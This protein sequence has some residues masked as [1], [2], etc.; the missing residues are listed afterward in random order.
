MKNSLLKFTLAASLILNLTVFA[1][2]GY[3]YYHQSRSWVSPFGK[4]MEKDKFLFEELSLKPEQLSAMKNKAM[5]F[6]AEIDRRRMAIDVRKKELVTLMRDQTP[7]KKAIDTIIKE[8]SGKQ[9]EMQRMI[10]GHMLEIKSSLDEGQQ[11]KFF[12]LIERNMAG[13]GQMSCPP[14][15]GPMQSN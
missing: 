12:D 15:R 14:T 3:H 6:R 8:I 2:A 4:V 10:V 1:T 5:P 7:D 13:S 9:E 11:R